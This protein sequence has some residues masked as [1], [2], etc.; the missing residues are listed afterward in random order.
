MYFDNSWTRYDSKTES[1]DGVFSVEQFGRAAGFV[2][3]T[4]T[5]RLWTR[6]RLTP[7]RAL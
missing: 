2:E 1:P 3:G 6:L 7:C 4:D 5:V